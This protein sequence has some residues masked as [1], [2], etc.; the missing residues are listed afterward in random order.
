MYL[1]LQSDYSRIPHRAGHRPNQQA[2]SVLELWDAHFQML[3]EKRV[4]SGQN[5]I[6]SIFEP[7]K[8]HAE[9]SVTKL[10]YLD[11]HS[12]SCRPAKQHHQQISLHFFSVEK[13]DF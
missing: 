3:D 2:G 1:E 10:V 4:K 9:K 12:L 5:S 13:S 7:L 11:A 6:S 8:Q